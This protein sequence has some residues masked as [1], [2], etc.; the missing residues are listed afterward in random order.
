MGGVWLMKFC[1]DCKHCITDYLGMAYAKCAIAKKIID[2]V[3]GDERL[4]FCSVERVN[5]QDIAC[6]PE[7]RHWEAKDD[8]S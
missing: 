7:G 4:V 1:K 2:P 3:T 8:K 6:G 5:F